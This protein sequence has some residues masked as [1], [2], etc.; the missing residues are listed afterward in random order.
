MIVNLGHGFSLLGNLEVCL[1]VVHNQYYLLS[2][3]VT[4]GPS[5][6]KGLGI[7]YWRGGL[8]NRKGEVPSEVLPI[9]NGG[10]LKKLLPC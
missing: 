3:G 7:D 6:A 5:H 9:Q 4:V 2:P 8:Q 1:S 10:G